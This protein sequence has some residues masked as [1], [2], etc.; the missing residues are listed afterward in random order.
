MSLNKIN[1]LF[2]FLFGSFTLNAQ[3]LLRKIPQDAKV[4]ITFNTKAVF[5]HLKMEDLNLTLI[6]L[7]L[8]D[9]IN[10]KGKAPIQKMQDL[11]IDWNTKAY[12]YVKGTDS[13]Q[14]FGALIPLSNKEQF[15][16]LVPKHKKIYQE[17]GLPTVYST[18]RSLRM[19]W[20]QHTLYV[21]GGIAIDRYFKKQDVKNRYGLIS[22]NHEYDQSAPIMDSVATTWEAYAFDTEASAIVDSIEAVVDATLLPP[23]AVVTDTLYPPVVVA[24]PPAAAIEVP[25]D[26]RYVDSVLAQEQ[27]SDDYYKRYD[28]M[29]R[30]NDSVKREVVGQWI[31]VEMGMVITG[32]HGSFDTRQLGKLNSNTLAQIHVRDI[33]SFYSHF[34]PEDIWRDAF[35]I[36]PKLDYGIEG[37]DASVIV[38]GNKLKF[39]GAAT[40]DK[41]MTTYYK[42]IYNKKAEPQIL[43]LSG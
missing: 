31:D 39:T 29:Y 19:S 42:A 41:D 26:Y 30:H 13:I 35:G 5:D 37:V 17:N 15:E 24:A 22:D 38:Q 12:A 3:N 6:R 4:V 43:R 20:D 14:Y 9:K 34:Y 27:Y 23:P 21:M 25:D 33:A 1:L 10:D 40:L 8:F 28:T 18:D 36:Q 7:G 2:I 32:G 16:S 11:G